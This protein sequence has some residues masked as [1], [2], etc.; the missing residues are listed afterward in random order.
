VVHPR[1]VRSKNSSF[2]KKGAP[3]EETEKLFREDIRGRKLPTGRSLT[4]W[5][6]VNFGLIQEK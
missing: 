4:S 6:S 3:L 1:R 5:L 2:G